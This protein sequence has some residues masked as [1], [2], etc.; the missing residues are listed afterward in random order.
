MVDSPLDSADI[1]VL[2]NG[3]AK[4]NLV[5]SSSAYFN[6]IRLCKLHTKAIGLTS[7]EKSLQ[8]IERCS[9]RC[10]SIRN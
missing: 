9:S 3:H 10:D 4:F 5:R 1:N 7:R 6:K 8:R 2:L